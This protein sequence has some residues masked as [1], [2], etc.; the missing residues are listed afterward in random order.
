MNEFEWRRQLR[1]LR[2][3][4]PPRRDLWQPISLALGDLTE[5]RPAYVASIRRHRPGI[6]L[7]RLAGVALAASFLLV[8]AWGWH[9]LHAP[10]SA[11]VASAP[12]PTSR[13]KPA[14]PRLSAAA[15]ELDAARIELQQAIEQAPESPSLRRLLARTEQQ[16]SQLHRLAGVAG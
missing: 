11:A 15:I 3:P 4:T 5:D 14:D 12:A 10:A 2:E 9:G 7:R 6:G 8:A 13:W 16:Q 1:D